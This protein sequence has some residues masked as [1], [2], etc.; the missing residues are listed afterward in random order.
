[1]VMTTVKMRGFGHAHENGY[2]LELE[3]RPKHVDGGPHAL[4]ASHP[5]GPCP[6]LVNHWVVSI[7]N[8]LQISNFHN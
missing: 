3:P 8:N 1:M 6:H 2:G 7:L 4:H 5:H